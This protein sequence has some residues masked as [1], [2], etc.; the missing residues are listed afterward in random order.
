M[1]NV[2]IFAGYKRYMA[3]VAGGGFVCSGLSTAA[4]GANSRFLGSARTIVWHLIRRRKMLQRVQLLTVLLIAVFLPMLSSP[5]LAHHSNAN[6]NQKVDVDL[7]GTIVEY[8]WGNPHVLV[9]WDVK[10][11][12]GKAVRWVGDL[13]S[14]ES[15]MASGMSRNTLRPGDPVIM[16]VHA[17][18]DGSPHAVIVRIRRAD[19]TMVL[20]QRTY[21]PQPGGKIIGGN[22]VSV[23]DP[24]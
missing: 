13:A 3:A 9:V 15:M 8:D 10:D 6:Y 18:K 17:A 23:E 20:A 19:G 11:A 21:G 22:G 1:K 2:F 24:K 16:T 5:A 12:G 14:V 7:K 4:P